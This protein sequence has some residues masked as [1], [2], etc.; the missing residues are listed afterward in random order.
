M[1]VVAGVNV[2]DN[3]AV[4]IGLTAIYGIGIYAAQSICNKLSIHRHCKVQE[5]S[6]L[7]LAKLSQHLSGMTI[8]NELKRIERTNIKRLIDIDSYRGYRH[9]DG[10][11]ANGQ[12][13]RGNH[14][15]AKKFNARRI[16][17]DY[18]WTTSTASL[19]VVS[20]LRSYARALWPQRWILGYSLYTFSRTWLKITWQYN[21]FLAKWQKNFA[22]NYNTMIDASNTQRSPFPFKR[23]L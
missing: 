13:T 4:R 23:T 6:E 17:W 2:P 3:K 21:L 9:K 12:R 19:M 16:M 5:L 22:L 14:K 10:L 8:E 11:P 15:T 7:Q 1:V 18:P 20:S